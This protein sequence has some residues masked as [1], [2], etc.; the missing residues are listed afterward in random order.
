M[1]K[2]VKKLILDAMDISFHL[3]ADPTFTA[4][5]K[6][7]WQNSRL[8]LAHCFL[9]EAVKTSMETI[10][11][12]D[13]LIEKHHHLL[14]HPDLLVSLSHTR[15]AAA[16][17]L[18]PKSDELL[19]V[20]IDVERAD[21]TIKEGV[22][23]KYDHPDDH[24]LNPLELWCAKEAAFKAASFYWKKEKTFI[25]KDISVTS[26]NITVGD[27]ILSTTDFTV[28]D[29]CLG[30]IEFSMAEGFLITTALIHKV[31]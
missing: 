22:L 20:G 1:A 28:R 12:E 13:L 3:E 14:H 23:E 10:T 2:H 8:A 15:G 21:R 24:G 16:A 5:R 17:I 26:T 7:H 31:L 6:Q 29:T 9:E 30:T 4:I 18:A 11:H 27:N 25:L 19:S